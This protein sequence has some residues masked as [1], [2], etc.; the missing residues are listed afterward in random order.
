MYSSLHWLEM[1]DKLNVIP[2]L[3]MISHLVCAAVPFFVPFGCNSFTKGN[4]TRQSLNAEARVLDTFYQ[5]L[6]NA[7]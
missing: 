2:S 7:R 6:E 5:A 4:K 1:S 3:I